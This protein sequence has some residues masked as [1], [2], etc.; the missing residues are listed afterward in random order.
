MS[1]LDPDSPLLALPDLSGVHEDAVRCVFDE[2]LTRAKPLEEPR[3]QLAQFNRIAAEALAY[4]NAVKAKPEDTPG[5]REKLAGKLDAFF[6]RVARYAQ[7][8]ADD[9]LTP[10][11]AAL[12]QKVIEAASAHKAAL[13]L[14]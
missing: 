2:R 12:K 5:R 6:N 13:T 8:H 3:V 11:A 14:E 1:L 4:W 10:E 9:T 7:F